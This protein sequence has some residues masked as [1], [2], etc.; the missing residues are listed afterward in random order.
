MDHERKTTFT[1]N[2]IRKMEVADKDNAGQQPK[3]P[4][5][6]SHPKLAPPGMGG[7]RSARVPTPQPAKDAA[8]R[9]TLKREVG[10]PSA[11]HREFKPLAAKMLGKD[12]DRSR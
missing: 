8:K 3:P 1:L 7:I 10:K 4:E 12:H 2:D 9:P 5:H 11:V 6:I